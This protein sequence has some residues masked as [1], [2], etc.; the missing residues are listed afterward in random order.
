MQFFFQIT[1]NFGGTCGVASSANYINNCNYNQAYDIL[2]HMYNLQTPEPDKTKAYE[3][4][5]SIL[6]IFEIIVYILKMLI[7]S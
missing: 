2:K 3:E 5:V 6:L 1:N 7:F 4:A